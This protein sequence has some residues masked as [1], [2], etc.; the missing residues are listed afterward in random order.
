MCRI[1]NGGLGVGVDQNWCR[2]PQMSNNYQGDRGVRFEKPS[3][4]K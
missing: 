1:H 4:C 3:C 2:D